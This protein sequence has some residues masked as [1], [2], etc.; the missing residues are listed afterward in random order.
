M[1]YK[2][3][4]KVKFKDISN[5]PDGEPTILTIACVH[6]DD[7]YLL[8]KSTR[9]DECR[10]HGNSWVSHEYQLEL[11]EPYRDPA[12]C[13]SGALTYSNFI[14][15]TNGSYWSTDGTTCVWPSAPIQ[16]KKTFM[17][18]LT[19]ALKKIL[20]PNLQAQY[21]AG[22]RNGDLELTEKGQDQLLELLA[23]EK[24]QELADLAKEIILEEETE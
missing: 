2:V 5:H 7:Y 23:T 14:P 17:Q 24:E 3:G 8:A 4:D 9:G 11:V 22:F 18:K 10:E 16:P 13:S 20:S 6:K 19:T 12:Y 1:E 15:F 21:K